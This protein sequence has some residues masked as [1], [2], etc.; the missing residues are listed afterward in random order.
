MILVCVA[1]NLYRVLVKIKPVDQKQITAF[2]FF[3]SNA[4]DKIYCLPNYTF[5]HFCT[6]TFLAP[7]LYQIFAVVQ[8]INILCYLG[9]ICIKSGAN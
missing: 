3:K 4:F 7:H 8:I 9:Q 5:V 6:S 1:V 2:P